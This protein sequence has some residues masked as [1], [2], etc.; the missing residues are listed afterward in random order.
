LPSKTWASLSTAKAP[1]AIFQK[2]RSWIY[3]GIGSNQRDKMI[4]QAAVFSEDH[5]RG[6][7]YHPSTEL[8][9]QGQL[10]ALTLFP[11]D[12]ILWPG[13]LPTGGPPFSMPR[14]SPWGR[15]AFS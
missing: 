4:H 12:Q 5:S 7:I 11:S 15:K 8:F 10:H 3:L 6:R 13:C 2:D 1:W 14:G 9:R